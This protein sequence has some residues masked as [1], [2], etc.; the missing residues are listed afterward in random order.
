DH[1]ETALD[2]A[3]GVGNRLA[4]LARER[5]R[6]LV[7]FLLRQL[8]ELHQH[9]HAALRVGSRPCWLRGLGVLD[10]RAQLLLG[11]QRQLAAHAAVHGLHE[12]LAAAALSGDTL[13]ADE[14]SD[15]EHDVSPCDWLAALNS[16][17]TVNATR[18][19]PHP[20]CAE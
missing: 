20:M 3:L 19:R 8:E 4:V 13:A 15:I 17:A 9:A 12:V 16:F 2:V 11:G 18:A 14:M 5:L 7:H 10:G 6:H 1:F